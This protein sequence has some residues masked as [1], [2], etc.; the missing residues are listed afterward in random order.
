MATPISGDE[1]LEY[2]RMLAL[3]YIL[4]WISNDDD[5][6]MWKNSNLIDPLTLLTFHVPHAGGFLK[7]LF[8][9]QNGKE[10]VISFS[11]A[12]GWKKKY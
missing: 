9:P 3:L 11:A 5:G 2:V 4:S 1:S 10:C 12:E 6:D 8:F 7:Y